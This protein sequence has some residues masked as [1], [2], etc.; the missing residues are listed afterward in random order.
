ML[1]W[2]EPLASLGW[3]PPAQHRRH[4]QV[5]HLPS[6]RHHHCGLHR[7]AAA[8]CDINSTMAYCCG[9]IKYFKNFFS[10]SETPSSQT[11]FEETRSLLD[12]AIGPVQHSLVTS[13]GSIDFLQTSLDLLSI[14]YSYIDA[15]TSLCIVALSKYLEFRAQRNLEK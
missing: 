8:P 9:V 15:A 1:P 12:L 5:L 6:R 10:I 11:F 3:I 4:R 7:Q 2:I 13:V 14:E